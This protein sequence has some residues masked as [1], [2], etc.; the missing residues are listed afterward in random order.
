MRRF[1]AATGAAPAQARA[2]DSLARIVRSV[3]A[4]SALARR[5]DWDQAD[6]YTAT[7]DGREVHQVFAAPGRNSVT[8]WQAIPGPKRSDYKNSNKFCKAE[9]AFWGEQF[10][11]RYGG[12]S[13]R[14]REVR[15]QQV[16]RHSSVTTNGL[17]AGPF[18]GSQ[19]PEQLDLRRRLREGLRGSSPSSRW[20]DLRRPWYRAIAA[21][22][23]SARSW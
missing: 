21:V 22:R 16:E 4:F 1:Y 8:D 13:Q 12:G 5:A 19:P 17:L 18:V 2:Q 9:Q 3:V 23:Q 10:A 14:L 11:S 20:P 6:I 7:T 15:E